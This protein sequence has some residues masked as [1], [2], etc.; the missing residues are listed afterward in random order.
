MNNLSLIKRF[1]LI[2][3]NGIQESQNTIASRLRNQCFASAKLLDF[4]LEGIISEANNK[5]NFVDCSDYHFSNADKIL[6]DFLRLKIQKI[7]R[8][9]IG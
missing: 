4:I 6:Y 3:L 2:S 5:Y 7:L 1:G 8:L 9:R